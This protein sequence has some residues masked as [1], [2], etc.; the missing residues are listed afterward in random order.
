[1]QQSQL[2]REETQKSL[3]NSTTHLSADL[4]KATNKCTEHTDAMIQEVGGEIASLEKRI[5]VQIRENEFRRSEELKDSLESSYKRV[6]AS[7]SGFSCIIE[8]LLHSFDDGS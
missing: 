4:E 6:V 5:G 3:Q 7:K 2:W 1:M 8:F